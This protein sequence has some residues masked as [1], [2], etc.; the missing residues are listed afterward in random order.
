MLTIPGR[1]EAWLRAAAGF[2]SSIRVPGELEFAS[3]VTI[4]NPTG[5]CSGPFPPFA[6]SAA[7]N[8]SVCWG[9]FALA[10]MAD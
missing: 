6:E 1:L 10:G 3:W 9:W 2:N 4:G 5:I 8:A 7:G